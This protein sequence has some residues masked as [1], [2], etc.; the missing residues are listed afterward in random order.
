VPAS[1]SFWNKRAA[2]YDAKLNKGPNYA[3]RLKRAA[4]VFG[5]NASVL[6]VGCATGEI[7]LDLAPH[8]GKI[9]GIDHAP[10]MIEMATAKARDRNVG[11]A[12]F[13]A[14]APDDPRLGEGT[15][16]AITTYSVIHLLDDVPGTLAR[17]RDLLVPG[18]HLMTETPCLRDW[19]PLWRLLL[20]AVVLVRVVPPIVGLR[21][22]ELESM[23]TNAGFE[24][25]D[26]KVYNPK[27]RQHC[28][29]ARKR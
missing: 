17:F 14:M 2:R 20:R 16:D 5:D 9:L 12:R 22:A 19:N 15:F 13:E 8:V 3:A 18:G 7:T 21:T 1:T 24:I 27:S 26:S 6:D 25:I 28:I 10:K 23:I 11:N 4:A 29:L